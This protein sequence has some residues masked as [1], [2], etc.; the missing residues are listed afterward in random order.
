MWS[1][2][3]CGNTSAAIDK[4]LESKVDKISGKGLSTNDFSN[5]YKS[6][7][8]GISS[9]V[10][11]KIETKVDKIEGMGLT[12]NDFTNLYKEKIDNI[13]SSVTF[14]LTQIEKVQDDVVHDLAALIFE[15]KQKNYIEGGGIDNVIVDTIDQKTDVNVM[16]GNFDTSKKGL[17][18]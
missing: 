8:D 14:E 3:A 12:S 13:D 10:D 17:Y 7:L 9:D 11:A 6:K 4:K 15:L 5:L 2:V 16:S 1:R 18:I